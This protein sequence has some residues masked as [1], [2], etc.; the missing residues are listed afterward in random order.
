MSGNTIHLNEELIKSSIKDL[1]RNSVEKTFNGL[2]E[3]KLKN[4]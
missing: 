3:H 1:V 2:R 4:W